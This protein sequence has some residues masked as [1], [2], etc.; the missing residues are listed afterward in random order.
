VSTAMGTQIPDLNE[1][2]G[3]GLF[4]NKRMSGR[5]LTRLRELVSAV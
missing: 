2:N 1:K 5:T 4:D 3:S